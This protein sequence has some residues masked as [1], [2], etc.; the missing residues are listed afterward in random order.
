MDAGG[1]GTGSWR[2]WRLLAGAEAGSTGWSR[3]G[4]ALTSSPPAAGPGHCL[5]EQRRRPGSWSTCDQS[6][7][8]QYDDMLTINK[9]TPD[10]HEEEPCSSLINCF[11]TTHGGGGWS[12][13]CTGF[14]W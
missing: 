12:W 5:A 9:N 10:R 4:T 14:L 2:R 13:S 8:D 1:L 6:Y 3:L 7:L 11:I